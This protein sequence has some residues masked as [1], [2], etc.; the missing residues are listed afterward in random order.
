MFNIKAATAHHAII[1]K[2]VDELLVKGAF[3]SLT[4][5]TGFYSNV[6]VVPKHMGSL[7]P[8]LNHKWF[9]HYMH[10]TTF[11]MPTIRQVQELFQ[12]GDYALSFDLKDAY[13][14]IPIVKHH[15][16]FYVWFGKKK[17]FSV[18]GLAIWASHSPNSFYVTY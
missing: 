10:I 5:N 7:G 1:Q 8:T 9:N 6:F 14:H 4:G 18:E 16:C 13:W 3:E 2:E 12:Q 17:P 15:S 11:K